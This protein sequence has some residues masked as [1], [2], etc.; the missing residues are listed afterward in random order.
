MRHYTTYFNIYYIYNILSYKY[1][2][3]TCVGK[4]FLLCPFGLTPRPQITGTP[5]KA[6][7]EW[8]TKTTNTDLWAVR[9]NFEPNRS[10]E[11]RPTWPR[12]DCGR[13]RP[14]RDLL[15]HLRPKQGPDLKQK[16]D[17]NCAHRYLVAHRTQNPHYQE[18]WYSY[19]L[20][21]TVSYF[22][23]FK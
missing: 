19:D 3:H 4:Y 5:W 13:A 22:I 6:V 7:E 9:A 10:D 17:D 2:I 12:A 16:G 8:R 18:T 23:N 14:S 21:I 11:T 1:Y 15:R 20:F